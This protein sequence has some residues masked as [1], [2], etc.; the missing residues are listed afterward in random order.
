MGRAEAG[1][2]DQ[3]RA[4]AVPASREGHGLILDA[5]AHLTDPRLASDLDAVL[6]R[7]K[8]AGVARILSCG[9]D[10]ASS[11]RGLGLAR[12]HPEIRVAVG[13]HPHRAATWRNDVSD[14][15]R[16]LAS[17][18]RVVAIGE[19]GVDL[20]GR[21][22]AQEDQER[23]F[24][25]QL[26]LAV[27]IGLPVVVHVRDAGDLARTIVDR[28]PGT[29]G[30]IHCYSEGP[31]QVAEWLRRG[32][33]LSFAGTVTYPKN[34]VLRAAAMRAPRD[35]LLVETDAPYLAPQG[36][37]G[38]RNEPAFVAETLAAVAAARNEPAAELER[39]MAATAGRLFGHR[40]T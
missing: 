22:A 7:A 18:E 21:S 23:A 13:V 11:E 36:R 4:R 15:L 3:N 32:F 19:I 35:A 31:D 28:V 24:E 10:L 39:G 9:E 2:S 40:W 38:Q 14:V 33:I 20:S 12:S 5:H 37:R 8:A 6:A 1:R 16:R 25:A 27:E 34:E 26:R 30:M 29:R 17:D